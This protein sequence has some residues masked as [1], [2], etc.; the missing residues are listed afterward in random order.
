MKKLSGKLPLHR[1][2]NVVTGEV[3]LTSKF[4]PK[5]WIDGVEYTQVEVKPGEFKLLRSDSLR[6]LAVTY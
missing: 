2:R 6:K 4:L 5:R 1:V 3:Y